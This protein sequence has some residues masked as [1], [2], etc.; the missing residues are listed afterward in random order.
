MQDRC[1]AQPDT[2]IWYRSASAWLPGCLSQTNLPQR[3]S[4]SQTCLLR[5]AHWTNPE[6]EA[7]A[8]FGFL[9]RV[10]VAPGACLPPPPASGTAA[11]CYVLR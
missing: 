6:Q 8:V 1:Y 3:A 11:T 4:A 9:K 2:G 7:W 10:R 5:H